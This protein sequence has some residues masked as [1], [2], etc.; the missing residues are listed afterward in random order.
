MRIHIELTPDIV[1]RIAAEARAR[2]VPLE[3]YAE[4]LL[5]EAIAARF[6]S[7]GQLS[8]EELHVMLGAMAEGADKLPKLATSAF[9]R[10]RFYENRLC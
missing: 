4:S 8:V 6:P 7:R 10:G 5:R 1:E 3:S 2:G 9:A